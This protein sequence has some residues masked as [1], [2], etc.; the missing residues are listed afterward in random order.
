MKSATEFWGAMAKM[1]IDPGETA[2]GAKKVEKTRVQESMESTLKMWKMVSSAL[3]EPGAV[4]SLLE[5]VNALPEILVKMA[6]TGWDRYFQL[7]QEWAQTMGR[8]GQRTEAYQFENLDQE[9]FQIWTEIYQEEFRRFLNIPQLGLTR[10]YQE[11]MARF[12][13][14]YNLLQVAMAEFMY[15]IYLPMEKSFKVLQENLEDPAKEGK[16]PENSQEYYRMWLKILEGHYMTLF[17]SPEYTQTLG[18]T[19]DS[20]EA[21]VVAKQEF[22]QDA[23]QTFPVPTNKDMDDLYKELYHLKK[24]VREL[25]KKTSQT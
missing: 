7:Q 11:K 10:F 16:M 24:R 5:G 15:L 22:F 23:F 1:W 18:K 12:A 25:E 9:A 6:K 4:D 14:K 20:I 17:K 21:F 8:I 13:D 19:L 2:T 3:S